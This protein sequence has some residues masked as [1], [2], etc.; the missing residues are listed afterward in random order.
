MFA[1]PLG[2]VYG[3][4]AH[5]AFS[6]KSV[7]GAQEGNVYYRTTQT[8]KGI[9]VF[10]E[11]VTVQTDSG[12]NVT[13]LLGGTVA[14][15]SIDIAHSADAKGWFRLHS[16]RRSDR[17]ISCCRIA[18]SRHHE[19]RVSVDARTV[20]LLAQFTNIRKAINREG[21]NL[22]KSVLTSGVPATGVSA[23][24]NAYSTT[25]T[26]VVPS[27]YTNL[28]VTTSGGTGDGDLYVRSGSAPTTSTCTCRSWATGNTESCSINSPTAKTYYI[29]VHGYTAASGTTLKATYSP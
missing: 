3:L 5:D 4:S 22:N 10:G 13:A 27:G 19:E 2:A 18:R 12:G 20:Q 26:I 25:Y 28:T 15:P 9:P 1:G 6:V 23:A 17:A 24:L 14:V 16:A 7:E 11:T 29:R 21:H 8:C